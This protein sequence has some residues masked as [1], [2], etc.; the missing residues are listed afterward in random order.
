MITRDE[1]GNYTL[2]FK[3][4]FRTTDIRGFYECFE[5]SGVDLALKRMR[6]MLYQ[7][8][9]EYVETHPNE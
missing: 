6:D 2:E 3:G 5:G 4:H 8:L 1:H 9:K 7:E